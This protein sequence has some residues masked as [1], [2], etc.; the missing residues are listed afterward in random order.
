MKKLD[1]FIPGE[2]ID[3]C[4]PTVEFAKQS[5]WY[6]WFNKSSITRFLDQGLFPN[7]SDEQEA[8]FLSQ[9][10]D[11]LIFIISN[12]TDYLGVVSLSYIDLI[13]KSCDLAI[14]IDASIDKRQS[15][16][17]A[18]EAIALITVHAF[19]VLG[20]NRISAG[21]HKDLAGWGQRM[22]LLG[23]KI[24]GIHKNKFVKGREVSDAVTIACTYD[25][26]KGIIENRGCLWDSKDQFKKRYK[27]LPKEDF[28]KKL[29]YF[30]ETEGTQYYDDIFSL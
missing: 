22:G 2:T 30:F 14:V 29:E 11:R 19:E 8:F 23:Y 6:S 20:I 26:Y 10:K 25:I 3:L 15:P 4:I 21:Q 27:G 1:V 28:T 7:T 13:K 12:K 17:I 16:Y 9:G 24:E 5:E 18:L